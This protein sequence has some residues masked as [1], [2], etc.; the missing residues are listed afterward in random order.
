[1][2]DLRTESAGESL[3]RYVVVYPK[4]YQGK[5]PAPR[6]RRGEDKLLS[7]TTPIRVHPCKPVADCDVF[8]RILNKT[9]SSR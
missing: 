1:M 7:L 4:D 5:A 6:H 2:G 9:C 8:G 3:Q